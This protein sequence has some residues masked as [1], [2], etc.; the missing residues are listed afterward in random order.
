MNKLNEITTIT[1]G[2]KELFSDD[3]IIW[4]KWLL[5]FATFI[6]TFVI[7]IKFKI[8]EKIDPYKKLDKKIQK[9]IK[10]GH[11][12]RAKLIDYWYEEGENN[13]RTFHGTYEYENDGKKYKYSTFFGTD[14]RPPRTIDLYYDNSPKKLYAKEE[15][16][17]Y[18]ISGL[19]LVIL[20]FSPF[21]VGALMVWLLGLAG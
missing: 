19:P 17:Y 16:H 4:G 3:P 13:S 18:V 14:V 11:V 2:L 8:D 21:I 5:V 6:L 10:K 12:I 7:R 9:A 15:Y 20:N 1:E